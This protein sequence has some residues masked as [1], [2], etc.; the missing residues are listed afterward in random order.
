MSVAHL[1]HVL[2]VYSW[3][4]HVTWKSP[5]PMYGWVGNLVGSCI[6]IPG[7]VLHPVV[8]NQDVIKMSDGHRNV[9]TR[10]HTCIISPIKLRSYTTM[11]TVSSNIR[12]LQLSSR[13]HINTPHT[14]T[15]R[16]SCARSFRQHSVFHSWF[17]ADFLRSYYD[18]R[19]IFVIFSAHST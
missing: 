15:Q 3:M 7:H 16:S 18:T 1:D 2:I 17:Y 11:A 5:G 19:H 4:E 10:W 13:S 14:G 8:N 12:A 6:P 9:V